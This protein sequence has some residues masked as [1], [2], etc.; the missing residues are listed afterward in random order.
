MISALAILAPW[1]GGRSRIHA[2]AERPTSGEEPCY[3]TR[4]SRNICRRRLLAFNSVGSAYATTPIPDPA[5]LLLDTW[6]FP[7]TYAEHDPGFRPSRGDRLTFKFGRL[8]L[9][10][11][12]VSDQCLALCRIE[13]SRS[14][15]RFARMTQGLAERPAERQVR[16]GCSKGRP[17]KD[18]KLSIIHTF[19][20]ALTP[21][22]ARRRPS[23]EAIPQV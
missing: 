3:P 21:G 13:P 18:Q 19:A 9:R 5:H 4:G 17:Y 16:P 7:N 6:G 1:R 12:T 10:A 8:A 15:Q 14:I 20:S 23:G 2:A 22:M 11:V